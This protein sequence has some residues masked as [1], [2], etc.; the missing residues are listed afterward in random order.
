[1]N[2]I[3]FDFEDLR[4]ITFVTS[5]LILL[6]LL[7]TK[8]ITIDFWFDNEIQ[9]PTKEDLREITFGGSIA[10]LILMNRIE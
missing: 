6:I 1:M 5:H 7:M 4:E 10:L 2:I 8:R 9:P 3:W